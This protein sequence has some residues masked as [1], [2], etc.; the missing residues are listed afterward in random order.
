[1]DFVQ[2]ALTKKF[3]ETVESLIKE[4]VVEDY[5]TLADSLG[6]NKTS[7]SNAKQGR[8]NVP[9]KYI[10]SLENKYKVVLI[11]STQQ[12]F[13]GNIEERLLRAEAH[14]EVYE[15]AIAGL[16]ANSKTKDKAEFMEKVGALRT[17]VSEVVNRRKGELHK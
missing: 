8:I 1:M 11:S 17:R 16:L 9:S 12:D 5:N 10:K 3:L 7:M 4:G 6:W 13:M 14:L 2:N 15:S